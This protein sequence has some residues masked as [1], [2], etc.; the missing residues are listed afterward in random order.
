MLNRV[1]PAMAK[2][3]FSKISNNTVWKDHEYLMLMIIKSSLAFTGKVLLK[4]E[5]A[6]HKL[7][8]VMKSLKQLLGH[9]PSSTSG[10]CTQDRDSVLELEELFQKCL[11]LMDD[12]FPQ[13]GRDQTKIKFI[14]GYK[15]QVATTNILLETLLETVSNQ[16]YWKQVK[17][18][19]I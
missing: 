14:H 1:I 9:V 10:K 12:K 18:P 3:T 5:S 11:E 2:K 4:N 13:K 19:S 15:I 8:K 7:H 17:V 16:Y 6:I